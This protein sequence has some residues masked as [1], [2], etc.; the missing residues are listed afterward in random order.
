MS[1]YPCKEIHMKIS[2][3][4]YKK[5]SEVAKMKRF[6]LVS[7]P[8]KQATYLTP[9]AWLLSLPD[10][11]KYGAKINK[12]G[13]E[14]IKPPYILLASHNSFFDFKMATKAIFPHKANYIVA[15]DGFINREGIMRK[16]GCFGKRKF[17]QDLALIKQIKHSLFINKTILMIYPE[18]RYSM[19]GTNEMLPD[20]LGKMMKMLKVPVVTLI[21]HGH[22]L[23]QPNWNLQNKRKLKTTADMTKILTPE[24]CESLSVEQ[25]NKRINENFRYDDYQW[26]LDNHIHIKEKNRAEGIHKI[27]YKCPHC[28][29]EGQ[30]DSKDHTLFCQACHHTYE[31][32]TLGQLKSLEGES[33]FTHVPTWYE[34]QREQV[35]LEIEAGTYHFEH[36]VDIDSHPNSSGFYRFGKGKLIHN[37]NGF[38]VSGQ[39]GDESFSLKK[40]PLENYGTHIEFNYFGKGD[41]IDIST[42]NDSFWMLSQARD[43][44]VVKVH[45][46]VEEL[47]KYTLAKQK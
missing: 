23:L 4:V 15:V 24:E 28:L 29:S 42:S 2:D 32:T 1:G 14:G 20:S 47:Y 8:Q 12:H 46:A 25:I 37:M 18:A 35:R 30:M 40:A 6:D 31:L 26:Q 41:A 36:E 22:H 33:K 11:L 17:I 39:W 16:V 27:L 10:L 19:T 38:V 5:P 43:Y 21:S 44:L 7:P 3:I 13:M 9:V 34:W 45:F